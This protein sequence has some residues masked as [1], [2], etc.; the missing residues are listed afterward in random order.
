MFFSGNRFIIHDFRICLPWS[1][2]DDSRLETQGDGGDETVNEC[3]RVSEYHSDRIAASMFLR[4]K[5]PCQMLREL[6]ELDFVFPPYR[7]TGWPEEGHRAL[8]DWAETLRWARNKMNLGGLTLRLVMA[9]SLDGEQ[10]P[11]GREEITNEQA[12]EILSAYRRIISPL[13]VLAQTD[14]NGMIGCDGGAAEL[15]DFHAQIAWPWI[16]NWGHDDKVLEHGWLWLWD[17]WKDRC[18]ELREEAEGLVIGQR[19]SKAHLGGRDPPWVSIWER[20]FCSNY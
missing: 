18:R 2:P 20:R 9:D 8:E 3:N 7:N 17:Y 4:E 12:E 5:V 14:P 16:W 1:T 15:R 6:R 10:P 11:P 13:A 19:Y